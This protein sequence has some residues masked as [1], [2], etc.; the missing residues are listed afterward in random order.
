[1]DRKTKKAI[2]AFKNH[3]SALE[4]ITDEKEGENWQAALKDTLIL[5][6]GEFSSMVKRVDELSFTKNHPY[7]VDGVIGIFDKYVYDPSSKK[8]FINLINTTI[9]YIQ[10]N[11]VCKKTNGNNMLQ[12]F[13]D[14]QIIAGAS[15]SLVF[16]CSLTFYIGGAW[17]TYGNEQK[18]KDTENTVKTLTLEKQKMKTYI[19]S[20][21][22]IVYRSSVRKQE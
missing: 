19:D 3:L 8:Q 17:A 18:L 10:D 14:A 6:T 1:M 12:S 5:Y 21:S 22:N 16:L 7:T 2:D 9:N 11:G 4:D 15:S 13:S 20:L